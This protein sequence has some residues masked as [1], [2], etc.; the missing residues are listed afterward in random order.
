MI[1]TAAAYYATLL[2]LYISQQGGI[3]FMRNLNVR[4]GQYASMGVYLN[5]ESSGF[6]EIR[7]VKSFNELSFLKV[8]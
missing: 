6:K 2:H 1:A 3:D 7:K 8:S 4:I 5:L